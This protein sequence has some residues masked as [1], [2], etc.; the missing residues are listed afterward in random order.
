MVFNIWHFFL[1]SKNA[2]VYSG[3]L[4]QIIKSRHN[5][6][7]LY[8]EVR[9]EKQGDNNRSSV[10]KR[11]NFD[12]LL[13]EYISSFC[14]CY[15]DKSSILPS[16]CF[17]LTLSFVTLTLI[18][19]FSTILLFR[20]TSSF[21]FVIFL[22]IIIFSPKT[23]STFST[24]APLM[25]TKSPMGFISPDLFAV[26]FFPDNAFLRSDRIPPPTPLLIGL[27]LT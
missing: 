1:P 13:I 12:Q 9:S 27:P 11:I 4:N 10:K 6:G 26:S 22:V 16:G 19:L 3:L 24:S 23:G 25:G 14:I 7:C 20:I 5:S 2:E 21:N 15:V 17:T 18:F 8:T